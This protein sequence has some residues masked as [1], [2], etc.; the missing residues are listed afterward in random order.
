MIEK[1]KSC[2]YND[3]YKC[4]YYEIGLEQIVLNECNVWA[5]AR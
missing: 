5:K 1:C 2:R 4:R 3:G